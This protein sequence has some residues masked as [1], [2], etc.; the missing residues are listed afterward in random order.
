MEQ[1]GLFATADVPGM[2][3]HT[4]PRGWTDLNEEASMTN[5]T[6]ERRMRSERHVRG[7][8]A[9][10]DRVV[11]A[12]DEERE[13]SDDPHV[14]TIAAC[15]GLASCR[16]A[17]VAPVPSAFSDSAALAA[18]VLI[19]GCCAELAHPPPQLWRHSPP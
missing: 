18:G 6:S 1:H 15:L 19:V 17:I 13:L 4:R 14:A 16:R 8:K 3:A 12:T 2:Y 9:E 11:V 5:G 7:T 10:A